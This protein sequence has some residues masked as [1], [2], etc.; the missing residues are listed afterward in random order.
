[1]PTSEAPPFYNFRTT[2]A[3][4]ADSL[5]G[6]V[7]ADVL[8]FLRGPKVE[9]LRLQGIE[10]VFHITALEGKIYFRSY[11]HVFFC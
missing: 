2:P 3:S 11:R 7:D 6:E 4:D 8:D 5:D 10:H 1:M 9:Q